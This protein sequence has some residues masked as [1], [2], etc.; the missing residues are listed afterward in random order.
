VG[1]A[2]SKYYHAD[3]YRELDRR[4]SLRQTAVPSSGSAHAIC[5]FDR[6]RPGPHT[7]AERGSTAAPA[8]QEP[9][10]MLADALAGLAALDAP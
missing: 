7:R 2:I 9:I 1:V 5:V 8:E 3:D 10:D 4:T 6:V